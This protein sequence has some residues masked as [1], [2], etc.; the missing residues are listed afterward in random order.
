MFVAVV[1][2]FAD[3]DVE[4]TDETMRNKH[5]FK[6]KITCHCPKEACGC[7]FIKKVT[8]YYV[9]NQRGDVIEYSISGGW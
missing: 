6:A 8:V 7:D 3:E 4:G 2:A 5:S 9:I 1:D